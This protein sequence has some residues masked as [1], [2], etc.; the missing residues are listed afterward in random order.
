MRSE[1]EN[2]HFDTCRFEVTETLA[3]VATKFSSLFQSQECKG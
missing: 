2:E 3:A 1:K